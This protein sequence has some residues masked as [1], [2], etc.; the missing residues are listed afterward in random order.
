MLSGGRRSRCGYAG[1]GT[2]LPLVLSDDSPMATA[3]KTVVRDATTGEIVQGRSVAQLGR[4][5]ALVK[6][7]K[8]AKVT[9]RPQDPTRVV[10]KAA[11]GSRTTGRLVDGQFRTAK[12]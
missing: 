9:V 1:I 4:G 7:G 2:K 6:V 3:K 11:D 8:A 5:L 10:R 12:A